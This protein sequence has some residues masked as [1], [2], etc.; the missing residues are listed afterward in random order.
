MTTTILLI[1]FGVIGA[2]IIYLFLTARRLKNMPETPESTKIVTL[3]PVNFQQQTKSGLVLIDFWASWCMPCKMMAPILNEIAEEAG[4][5]AKIA[6]VNV[7]EFQQLS[8]KFSVRNI[9]TLVLM[10]DGKEID[11]FVGV[12]PKDFLLKQLAKNQ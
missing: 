7:E 2:G 10:K 3:N 11:R 1:V 9:P 5:K 6:K 12:K 8:A 4:D